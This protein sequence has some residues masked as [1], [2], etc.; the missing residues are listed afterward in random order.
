MNHGLHMR[1]TKRYD[2]GAVID[3][4]FSQSTD[5]FKVTALFGPSGSG[6]TTLLRCLAGLTRPD[7]GVIEFRGQTWFDADRGIM[8]TP[9]QRDIGFLFQEYALF[10]HLT[11]A[12]NIGFGLFH[13]S[14]AQRLARVAEMLTLFE[15]EG[16][17]HR[18][19]SQLS[20]GQQQRVA[21]ARALARRP[22]LL[23]LDEPL[24]A[25]DALLREQLRAELR[26]II[27]QLECPVVM[28]THDRLEAISMADHVAVMNRGRIQQIGSVQEVFTRPK[29]AALA[30]LVGMETI[31]SGEI[32]D[33]H[34][35]LATVQVGTVQLLAVAPSTQQRYVHVCIRGEDVA[36]QKG[37]TGSSSVRNHLNATIQ[38]LTPEGPLIRVGLDCGFDL[39]SLITRPASEELQL[40]IGDTVTA[41]LKAPAIHLISRSSPL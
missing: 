33:V 17:D 4:D 41:M 36:L 8:L 34:E 37:L 3:V 10:P 27:A 16:L 15:L 1:C 31:A 38:S 39:T 6:K 28:V 26:R 5:E 25:L 22:Q 12:A 30:R 20:G 24:S 23:L 29:N 9:Q 32:V 13:C 19:P 11:V 7:D 14:K 18:L 2:A 35:G 21:L 40:A